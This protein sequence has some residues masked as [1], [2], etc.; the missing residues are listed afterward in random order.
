MMSAHSTTALS[1]GVTASRLRPADATSMPGHV[2]NTRSAVG[3]R[4]RLRLQ[5][6]S[7]FTAHV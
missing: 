5:M 3:L 4:S 7:T 6:K 2:E 1:S